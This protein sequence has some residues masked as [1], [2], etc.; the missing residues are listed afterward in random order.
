M[1][2]NEQSNSEINL[3]LK[4]PPEQP[5]GDFSMRNLVLTIYSAKKTFVVWC[6]IGLALG[7]IAAAGYF[8]LNTF[9]SPPD[10]QGDVTV[11]LTLNYDGAENAMLPNGV[12]FDMRFFYEEIALWEN[13]LKA[14]GN[15]DVTVGD[16]IS[17]VTIAKQMY[18]EDVIEN[19][20]NMTLPYDYEVFDSTRQKQIF[21]EA[22][23]EEYKKFVTGKYFTDISIG[24]LYGQQVRALDEAG[25]EIIWDPFRFDMNFAQLNARYRTLAEILTNL[26]NDDP[27]YRTSEGR[28]FSDYATDIK[29]I[30]ISEIS[31]WDERLVNGIYIRN[32]DRFIEEGQY[33]LE[34]LERNRKYNLELATMYNDLL[35]SFQ[36]ADVQGVIVDEAVEM[37]IEAKSY[38]MAAADLQRQIDQMRFLLNNIRTNERVISSNSQEAEAALVGFINDLGKNQEKLRSVIYEYY[39]QTHRNAAESSVLYSS[40]IVTEA[41]GQPP[42]DGVS[43]TRLLMILIG[44]T[45]VGFLIGFCAT[46]VKKYIAER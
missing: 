19:V 40:A 31:T 12:E 27:N 42:A 21:L 9:I 24:M 36:Q 16:L 8:I 37:L 23:G 11:T 2:D 38:A 41:E 29:D 33:R 1:L 25:A 45:F 13:A 46:F 10:E 39:A 4:M 5:D 17:K 28:S 7:I 30:Y 26:F 32:I 22:L 34:A 35:A 6:C 43:F 44:L 15:D 20:F 14:V 3:N 18:G